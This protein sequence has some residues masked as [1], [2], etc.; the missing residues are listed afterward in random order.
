MNP[1]LQLQSVHLRVSDLARSLR[2]Y[3]GQLGFVQVS[4]TAARADLAVA[5]GS[6]ALLTL[7]GD[8]AA[9]PAP[10]DAAGL[11]HAALLLP[12]RAALAAWLRHAAQAGVEF[13][14]FSDHGVSEAVYFTDPDG[15]GLEFYT[16]RPR[17]SWPFVNGRLAMGTDPLDLPQLLADA[18]P[19]GPPPLAGAHWGHL[20]LRVTNLDRSDAFYRQ[21]LGLELMQDSF[22]G[23]RFLA[24]DGYHHHLGLNVWGRPR[25]PRPAAALGLVE[26]GFAR[27]N[28]PD[29]NRLADPDGIALRLV[30]L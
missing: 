21:A 23:A 16:D 13:D 18:A 3:V 24:A 20:H 5:A 12:G 6:P 26:A 17:S 10:S 14:G 9:P 22:A 1:S 15:N 11:F 25:Q 30:G 7:T 19:A 27:A 8:R 29:G 28:H 4:G 2:F